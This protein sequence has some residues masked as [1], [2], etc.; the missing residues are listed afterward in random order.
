MLARICFTCLLLVACARPTLSA[1][2]RLDASAAV[3][4][5]G[6]RDGFVVSDVAGPRSLAD[7]AMRAPPD[8]AQAD[9]CVRPD[10]SVVKDMTPIHDMTPIPDLTV[11]H[12]MTP[13]GDMT[14]DTCGHSLCSYWS[15]PMT[16]GCHWCVTKICGTDPYCCVNHWSTPCVAEVGTICKLSCN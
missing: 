15:Q 13:T 4:G 12:D 1:V 5:N 14:V 7:G 10:L 6:V 2:D 16:N 3:G 11:I 8:L 9:L